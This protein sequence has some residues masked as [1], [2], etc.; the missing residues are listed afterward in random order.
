MRTQEL[1][2]KIKGIQTLESIKSALNVDRARAIYL[3]YRLKRKGYVKTQYTSDK[4]R[5]YHIS[6]EN[7]LGG[8]SYV[9]IINKYSPIKLSSSEVHKIH[10]R[11]P[12]IE[13]TLVYSVKTRKIRYILAALVLYR[14]VKN[15]SELYRLAK[16]NNLVREIGALYD[17]ARKKVGKVRRM[18][19]RFINHALPKEDE[20]YRF[21]I[22]HLQSKDFQN[23]ENRWRVHVPFNENDLEDYKK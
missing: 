20:S 22:Q 5:V 10:G 1:V 3:V 19:K 2:N 14:K 6:P 23:I 17:V 21:V 8:T 11:V 15:W 16:E 12:S 18:E 4:K 13:E 7:V 9:D